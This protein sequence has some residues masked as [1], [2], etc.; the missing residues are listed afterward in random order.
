MEIDIT[1]KGRSPLFTRRLRPEY[2]QEIVGEPLSN[3]AFL[4]PG[5]EGNL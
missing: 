5:G 2:V 1:S 4:V 3:G